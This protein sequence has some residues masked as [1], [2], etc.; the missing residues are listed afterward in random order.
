MA[1]LLTKGLSGLLW[2]SVVKMA[3][4]TELLAVTQEAHTLSP[5]SDELSRLWGI[6]PYISPSVN[7]ERKSFSRVHQTEDLWVESGCMKQ[8]ATRE[9]VFYL[10][11]LA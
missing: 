6:C 1:F 5:L 4:L 7:S 2:S 3:G 11:S 9:P 10:V 8:G